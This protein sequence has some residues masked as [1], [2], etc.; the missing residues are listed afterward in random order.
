MEHFTSF[1]GAKIAFRLTGSGRPTL[2]V[3]GFLSNGAQ[4]WIDTGA[5]AAVAGLGRMLIIP[6]LRGHGAS[7]IGTCPPD[8]LAM[9]QEA[10]LSQLSV[11]D[12]DLIGYSLGAH[13][14]IRMIVR[15]A[16][17]GR[18]VLAGMGDS[19]FHRG[20]RKA[21]FADAIR[22]GPTGGPAQQAIDAF[23]VANKIDR[24]AALAVLESQLDTKPEE[25]AAYANPVLVLSGDKDFD[26][27]AIEPLAAAFPNARAQ[28][29]EGNHM[30]APGKASFHAALEDFLR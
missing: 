12:Y 17:P 14:A 2:M 15:G 5:A 4:N 8:A 24:A 16:R 23:L 21:L 27:G 22:N 11:T 29:C 6:D 3:H 28:R 19:A 13:T 9:D 30:N 20:A 7:E 10:L 18:L 25:L 26:N 1:D